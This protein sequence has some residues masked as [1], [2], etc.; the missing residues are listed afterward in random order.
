[1]CLTVAKAWSQHKCPSVDE[2][3][4][5]MEQTQTEHHSTLERKPTH[6]IIDELTV[7]MLTEIS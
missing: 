4:S 3:K 6:C 7:I 5:D 1:M 2:C